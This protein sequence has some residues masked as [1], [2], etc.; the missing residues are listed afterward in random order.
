MKGNTMRVRMVTYNHPGQVEANAKGLETTGD[1]FNNV[2]R[3][4][5]LAG[6]KNGRLWSVQTPLRKRGSEHVSAYIVR[7]TATGT[8]G[9]VGSREMGDLY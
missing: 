7:H 5:T 9:V 8:Y 2:G 6:D 1:D 3:R 4:C